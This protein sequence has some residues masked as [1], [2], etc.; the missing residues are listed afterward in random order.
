MKWYVAT[1][2]DCIFII[3]RQPRPAPIDYPNP[4]VG[5]DLVISMRSGSRETQELAEA[6]V[7]AHNATVPSWGSGK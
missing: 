6:I 3:N 1:M 4:R 2:N 7:A 5:P